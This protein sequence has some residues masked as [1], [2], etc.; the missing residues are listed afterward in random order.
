MNRR[1]WFFALLPVL[2]LPSSFAFTACGDERPDAATSSGASSNDSACAT[3]NDGCECLAEGTTTPCG[4]VKQHIGEYVMC[5]M[6]DRTCLGG[7]WGACNAKEIVTKAAPTSSL[8]TAALAPTSAG[9]G[10]INPCDP[11]CQ[12]YS[13]T[14]DNSVIGPDSGLVMVDGGL[15][16]SGSSFGGSCTSLTIAPATP[17]ITIT[18]LT[19]LTTSPTAIAF[20]PT[21]LPAGCLPAG[22]QPTWTVSRPDLA[23]L[24]SSG[25]LSL[26]GAVAGNGLMNVQAFFGSLA[27]NVVPVNVK[28]RVTEDSAVAPNYASPA[29]Q[30]AQFWTDAA[31][32]TA[33][34][35]TVA[36]NATWLYPYADTFFPLGLPPPVVQYKMA[37]NA[38]NS[39]KVSLRYP[40]GATSAAALFEYALVVREATCSDAAQCFSKDGSAPPKLRDPQ[41]VIPRAAWRAFEQT[42]AGNFA[43][44]VVQRYTGVLQNESPRR[45]RFVNGQLKGTVFY[46]TYSSPLVGNTGAVMKVVPGATTPQVGIQMQGRCTTCHMFNLDGTQAYANGYRYPSGG[47]FNDSQLF[48]LSV[49]PAGAGP[50]AVV[51]R[52]FNNATGTPNPGL[53]FN[54]GAVHTDGRLYLT[55]GGGTGGDANFRAP[56]VGSSFW[57]PTTATPTAR[58]VTGWPSN[59]QAITPRFSVAGNKIAFSYWSGTALNQSPSGTLSPASAGTTLAVVDFACAAGTGCPGGAVTNARNVTPGAAA[60]AGG[61]NIMAWPSFT[62][63]GTSVVYQRQ[64]VNSNKYNGW[65]PSKINTTTGAQAEI[66]MSNIPASS[67]TAATPTRLNALNGL[68]AAGANY[69]P[70]IPR[71]IAPQPF[72]T[73]FHQDGQTFNTCIADNCGNCFTPTDGVSDTR[74]NYR[75]AVL[76]V[77]AGGMHWVVFGSRR[78]YGSVATANP[79]DAEPG[80]TCNSQSPQPKKLWVAAVDKTWTPGTDPSHAAFYL[81]GQELA[82]GNSEAYW[83]NSAC[84]A[85]AGSCETTADCCQSPQATSCRID[86]PV[87]GT[88][89]RSCQL[90]SAC[91]P[92]GASCTVDGDCCG[93]QRC[94]GSPGVCAPL[95][96]YEAAAI[97]RDFS[98][99]CALG[100]RIIWQVFQWQSTTPAGSSISFSAQ[101]GP[102]AGA[103]GAAVP[104]GTA[105]PSGGPGAWVSTPTSVDQTLKTAAPPQYSQSLLRVTMVLNTNGSVAPQL[106]AWRQLYDCIPEE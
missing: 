95:A 90:A 67:S 89:T 55:H 56:N 103:L 17:S 53:R 4:S 21:F 75:P 47:G 8:H 79:W 61:T 83:V 44:L 59:T 38:G 43:D 7:R 9:C 35:P 62:P 76:P 78:M 102:N 27:S 96:A 80:E 72:A 66:W 60:L 36:T 57:D 50:S 82:A 20:T 54:Y 15:S 41:I 94:L 65:S 85:L 100:T 49:P 25:S 32:V 64:I 1:S 52:Q 45:I 16:L 2:A 84:S 105:P 13:D 24:S 71:D 22:T 98:A 92:T 93:T 81:P 97:T 51:L 10:S 58:S 91:V 29:A 26:L 40:T 14:P 88:V 86:L 23:L 77:E 12:V 70:Q 74:L 104:I 68:T 69:L 87:S 42:A 46:G 31:R 63:D 34:S 99:T 28:L 6:G 101:T 3:P 33:A 19:P 5:S 18:D 30:I 39:V 11:Y 48:D 37:A 106:H 73:N